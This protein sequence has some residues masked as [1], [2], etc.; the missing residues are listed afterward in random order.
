MASKIAETQLS[1][2][3]EREGLPILTMPCT[4]D[5]LR[6]ETLDAFAFDVHARLRPIG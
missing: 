3:A 1:H 5:D 2:A 4:G 6:A